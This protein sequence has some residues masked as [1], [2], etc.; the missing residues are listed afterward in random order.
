LN[1]YD[2][3]ISDVTPLYNLSA[4]TSL[5]L[6]GNPLTPEQI[7]ELQAALPTCGIAFE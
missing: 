5:Y 3:Q 2:N 4:L 7:A 6:T 1:L